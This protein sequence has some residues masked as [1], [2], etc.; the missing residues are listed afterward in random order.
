MSDMFTNYENLSSTYVP[1]NRH[2][3]I[4]KQEIL[5]YE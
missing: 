1:D 5:N 2:K 4:E 3:E